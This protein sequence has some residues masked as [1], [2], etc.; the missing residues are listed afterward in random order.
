MFHIRLLSVGLTLSSPSVFA[1]LK[2]T[3]ILL[4]CLLHDLVGSSQSSFSF[5]LFITL[6]FFSFN[7]KKGAGKKTFQILYWAHLTQK[8]V[9]FNL[10]LKFL[11]IAQGQVGIWNIFWFSHW[12]TWQKKAKKQD[13]RCTFFKGS[14][15]MYAFNLEMY[16]SIFDA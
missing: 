8:N 6:N 3:A 11:Q 10:C 4:L 7:F 5:L 1:F 15:T 12:L 13:E 16:F 9:A 2:L 14:E